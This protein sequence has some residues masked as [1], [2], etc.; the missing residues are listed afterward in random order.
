MAETV[1]VA[2]VLEKRRFIEDKSPELTHWLLRNSVRMQLREWSGRAAH[3]PGGAPKLVYCS[4]FIKDLSMKELKRRCE[5]RGHI[6]F[7]DDKLIDQKGR[8]DDPDA[9]I[10][11]VADLLGFG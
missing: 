6:L 5:N 8:H 4:D 9:L 2:V 3:F 1:E 7:R 11:A 10:A